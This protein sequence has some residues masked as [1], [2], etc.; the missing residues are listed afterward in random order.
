MRLIVLH[1][2]VNLLDMINIEKMIL[3]HVKY[4]CYYPL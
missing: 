4:Q 2:H 1:I 3:N